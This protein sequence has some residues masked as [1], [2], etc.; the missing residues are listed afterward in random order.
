MYLMVIFYFIIFF[1]GCKIVIDVHHDREIICVMVFNIIFFLLGFAKTKSLD[2]WTSK[3][4]IRANIPILIK[5]NKKIFT[6]I[7][8]TETSSTCCL[9]TVYVLCKF[10]LTVQILL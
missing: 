3:N 6:L 5:K 7:I 1:F 10:D 2:V 4:G 9:C 8:F